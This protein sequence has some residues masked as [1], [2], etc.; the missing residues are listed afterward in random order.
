MLLY[1]F[2]K[3]ILHAKNIFNSLTFSCFTVIFLFFVNPVFAQQQISIPDIWQNYKFVPAGVDGFTPLN[4]GEHYA[5]VDADV[6]GIPAIYV[7]DYKTAAKTDSIFTVKRDV[8]SDSAKNFS[9]GS[10]SF[11][12]IRSTY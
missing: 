10:F 3:E 8:P 5:S 7:Y 11:D 2:N 9:L 1:L 12:K 4:D 6:N